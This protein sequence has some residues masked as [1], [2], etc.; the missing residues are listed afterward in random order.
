[1]ISGKLETVLG[2][3]P[4]VLDDFKRFYYFVGNHMISNKTLKRSSSSS[5]ALASFL[6]FDTELP[7][8]K[9]R[10]INT[11]TCKH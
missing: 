11:T 7:I 6:V 5:R 2:R 1:M 10:T 8:A 9:L 4:E 3:D